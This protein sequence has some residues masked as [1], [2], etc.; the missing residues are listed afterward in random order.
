MEG[1]L[2]KLVNKRDN[3]EELQSTLYGA[4]QHPGK[5][6]KND[7]IRD[8]LRHSMHNKPVH[9]ASLAIPNKSGEYSIP[10]YISI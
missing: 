10:L 6:I 1:D 2:N 5:N 4:L 3:L 8:A 9:S 7:T